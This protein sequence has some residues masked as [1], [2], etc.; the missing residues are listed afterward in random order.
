[1]IR[2]RL[3]KYSLFFFCFEQYFIYF[4]HLTPLNIIRALILSVFRLFQRL[5]LLYYLKYHL[6]FMICLLNEIRPRR[7][8]G[9][10]KAKQL[11]HPSESAYAYNTPNV[12]WILY[13]MLG[14]D[15]G[16]LHSYSNTLIKNL[17]IFF[18]AKCHFLKHKTAFASSP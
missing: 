15:T 12:Y 6:S 7:E 14:S 13:S 4:I 16:V 3:F 11:W 18:K 17:G 1:M 8:V 2:S 5:H 10:G 9:G